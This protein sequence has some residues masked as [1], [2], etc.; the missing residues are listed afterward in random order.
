[1]IA[2]LGDLVED[3][4][5]RVD[6]P[7]NVAS[8][9]D[10]VIT[11]RRGGSAANV[12]ATAARLGASVRFLG[13][14][15]DDPIGNALVA[16]LAADGVDVSCVRRGGRTGTIAVMVDPYGE[17]TMLTD[18][19]ACGHLA[20]PR[21]CWLVGVETLHV[22]MYSL[23]GDTTAATADTVIGWARQRGIPVSIDLSSE[24][25]IDEIG[26]EG[27]LALLERLAPAVV[28]ANESEAAGIGIGGGV[29]HSVT[30]V[31]RGDGPTTCFLP[32]GASIEVPVAPLDDLID[33]TGAGDAFA[34]GFLIAPWAGNPAV[35]VER[36][37][38]SARTHI[39]AN[40]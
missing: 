1:M 23:W 11:R 32:D 2:T 7:V 34:A 20:D 30:V 37:H 22:P 24:A 12:A 16:E 35:A 36:A 21:E 5:I 4:V 14:V 39:E 26:A 27:V 33:T 28:F 29:G 25:L 13:Q 3:I 8:D 6:D 10:A 15:G 18:R 19:G 38:A 17:R 31:K 9:T 40:R